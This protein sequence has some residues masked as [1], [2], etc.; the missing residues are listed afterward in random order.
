MNE[1]ESSAGGLPSKSE[2]RIKAEL[3]LSRI[4]WIG[5]ALTRRLIDEF[6]A[7]DAILE[8]DRRELLRIQGRFDG[9]GV[10]VEGPDED[11]RVEANPDRRD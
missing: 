8:A 9:V 7:P 11:L 2:D 10:S 6:G 4:P 1:I 3:C 5:P